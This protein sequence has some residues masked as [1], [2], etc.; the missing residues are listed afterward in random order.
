MKYCKST[1]NLI[2]YYESSLKLQ[3]ILIKKE[4]ICKK[5]VGN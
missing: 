4:V 1:F 5:E 2:K 3:P